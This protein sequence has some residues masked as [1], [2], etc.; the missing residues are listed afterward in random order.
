MFRIFYYIKQGVLQIVRNLGMSMASIFSIIA[1]LLILGI[2]FTITVNLNLFTEE[3]KENYNSME[4]FLLDSTGEEETQDLIKDIEARPG[5]K[6]VTFR[7]KAEALDIMKERWGENA[8]LLDTYN[9]NNPL[10]NSLV[11][12]VNQLEDADEVS[13]YVKNLEG[14]E[15]TQYYKDT[16]DKISSV[17]RFIQ[18]A[19]LV[20]MAFL[21]VVSTVVVANT[22]KLTVNARAKEIEI[23]K[24][25]GATNWFIRG[26]FLIEGVIIGLIGAVISTFL[27]RWIYQSL[28]D[29][30]RLEISAVVSTPLI[31]SDYMAQN[32]III[33]L[34]LGASIGAWGSIIPMR[35]FLDT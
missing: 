23:M 20:I 3:A 7:S 16:V 24:Y 5:V 35:K 30:F 19:A 14:I 9:K 29:S 10:P 18:V 11:I 6:S 34:A 17:S 32:L 2:F 25:V 26:P 31:S 8:S 13:K 4:L 27:V 15:S 1:M 28:I 22:V 33:F 21:V 12:T